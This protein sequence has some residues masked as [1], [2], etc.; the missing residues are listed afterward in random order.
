MGIQLA[1]DDFGVGYS[2]LDYL[3]RY[4]VDKLKLDRSFVRDIER[5]LGDRKIVEAMIL[6]G[7]SLNL[8]IVAEGVESRAQ[9]R[10]LTD[11]GCDQVQGYLISRPMRNVDF[12]HFAT[13]YC[14]TTSMG[15]APALSVA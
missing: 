15:A 6:L 14:I 13:L 10:Y 4:P 12:L 8:E 1:I 5:D 11:L 7:K 2:S 9:L 3:R